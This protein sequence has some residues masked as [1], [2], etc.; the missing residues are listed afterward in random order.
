MT[1]LRFLRTD[2]FD[3]F[4]GLVWST[5]SWVSDPMGVVAY[6]AEHLPRWIAN[7]LWRVE[8]DGELMVREHSVVAPRARLAE[9]VT[10]WDMGAAA[11]FVEWLVARHPGLGYVPR[12]D[13]W[14]PAWEA[15]YVAA[16][17]AA[18]DAEEAGQDYEAGERAEWAAQS[19]WLRE[20][21]GVA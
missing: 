13:A 3:P 18:T 8:L 21:L 1:R 4:C 11:D 16:H 17:T 9:R 10:T 6:D 7:E 2:A 19:E 12:R 15:A 14:T 20:R 5:Q